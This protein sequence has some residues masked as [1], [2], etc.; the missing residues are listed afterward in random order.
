MK[1]G[2][3]VA[4]A[5]SQAPVII[6]PTKTIFECSKLMF[7]KNV[8]SILIVS[9]DKLLGILTE[10]DLVKFISQGLNPNSTS[11]KEVMTKKIVSIESDV[12]IYDALVKMRNSKVR[13]LPVIHK[14]RLVGML[15]QNDILKLQPALFDILSEMD[16][17]KK[18]AS[19]KFEGRCE[20]CD[21]FSELKEIGG[22]HLCSECI[23]D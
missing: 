20:N 1:T 5:M 12:D 18:N 22:R 15:T 9:N 21:N 11:V 4:D 10:K 6:Q 13:R 2:L 19:H 3:K 17:L 7:K 23:G 16:V 8:G 14:N